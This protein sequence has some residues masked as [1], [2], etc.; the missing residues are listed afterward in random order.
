[1]GSRICELINV[2]SKEDVIYKNDDENLIAKLVM[3]SSLLSGGIE[4]RFVADLF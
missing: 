3:Q 1:M 4:D 2:D